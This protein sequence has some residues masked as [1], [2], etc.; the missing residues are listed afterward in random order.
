MNNQY[1]NNS[2]LNRLRII[3]VEP[4]GALNVGSVARV[5]KN[6]GLYHLVLV[7]PH[8]DPLSEEARRMAVHG[9]EILAAAQRVENLAQAL[10]GCQRAIATTARPRHLSTPLETPRQALPWLLQPSLSTA[11][12]FG[13]EDRGLSNEE[14]SYAQRFVCIGANPDYPSLNLAQAVAICAYELYQKAMEPSA[15]NAADIPEPPPHLAT[16]EAME[17]YYAHLERVLLN[18]GYL[19]PHTAAARLEKFR[20][21]Y[22]RAQLTP[23]ELALLRGIL[24]HLESI[25]QLLPPT[26]SLKVHQKEP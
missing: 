6:M 12:I 25:W 9:Q 26:F 16:I 23:A 3:L 22:N 13:P 4:A 24:G 15:E 1:C 14:L 18:I 7:N 5:M 21:I 8:C 11:L 17:G 19:Y 10:A 2:L 20:Q